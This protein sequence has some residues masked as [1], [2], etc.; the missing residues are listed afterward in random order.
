MSFFQIVWKVKCTLNHYFFPFTLEN[1]VNKSLSDIHSS[2]LFAVL[3]I[4]SWMFEMNRTHTDLVDM[5]SIGR[6]Y[7]GKPLY[8]LQVGE[9]VWD[10][11]KN[12]TRVRAHAHSC[13]SKTDSACLLSDRK[14]KSSS[15]ESC[16]DRLWRPCQRVDRTCF[17][18]VVCQR[19]SLV[20]LVCKLEYKNT[21]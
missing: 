8:V 18:P 2:A 17:L 1:F 10:T 11:Q 13:Y 16:L 14:E 7:E 6:S 20:F 9:K 21:V 15:E 5:F 12:D 4:Q 3:K 19:G